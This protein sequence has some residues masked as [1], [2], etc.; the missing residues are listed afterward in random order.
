MDIIVVD[1]EPLARAR[2]IKLIAEIEGCR[3]L[4]EAGNCENAVAA[5]E[6]HDPDLVL[7]DVRMPGSN[8][9]NAA[10]AINQLDDPPAII[11][12]TAY[13]EYA[14]NAFDLGAVGYLLK[15]VRIEKL[16]EVLEKAKKVNRVQRAAA[17]ESKTPLENAKRTHISA[18]TR[19]GVKLIDINHVQFF[20]ADQKYVTCH[21]DGGTLLIDDTLKE[22]EQEFS[23]LFVRTHRNAL[24]FIG[25]IEA[26]EKSQEGTYYLRLKAT[27]ETP[28]VSR[29]HVSKVK[30]LLMSL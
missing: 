10:E 9:L 5:V 11:F 23:S 4:D 18:K 29:R 15:P 25:A 7:L 28:A 8:G 26:M 22:L 13:D 27:E 17:K 2:L 3:V 24:V 21:Y 16:K 6:R 14:I 12:C 20:Q 19:R 30:E 1:D